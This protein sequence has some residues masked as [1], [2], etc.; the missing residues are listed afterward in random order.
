M[1]NIGMFSRNWKVFIGFSNKN[2]IDDIDVEEDVNNNNFF[3]N[4]CIFIMCMYF[5]ELFIC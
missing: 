2:L 3:N 1:V 4:Y 5:F